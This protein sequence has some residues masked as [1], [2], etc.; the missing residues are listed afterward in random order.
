MHHT[1]NWVREKRRHSSRI[2]DLPPSPVVARFASSVEHLEQVTNYVRAPP[3]ESGGQA[4]KRQERE[5]LSL[6]CDTGAK[7]TM[8]LLWCIFA[9]SISGGNSF[10][11]VQ[12]TCR[13]R[14]NGQQ[15]LC[16]QRVVSPEVAYVLVHQ[17]E[18][19]P[20]G[21]LCAAK[22][23]AL[24]IQSLKRNKLRGSCFRRESQG[25]KDVLVTLQSQYSSRSMTSSR[26]D[27]DTRSRPMPSPSA[28]TRRYDSVCIKALMPRPAGHT[29][30]TCH[31][32]SKHARN[33]RCIPML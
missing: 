13:N 33:W 17:H 4:E 24:P 10:G 28:K 21:W 16:L 8:K 30:D 12:Y 3:R 27:P 5:R 7:A 31:K 20:A 15:Q 11:E 29:N 32:D 1:T 6:F 19:P 14:R 26:H 25:L 18:E 22:E 2:N 23:C 9:L